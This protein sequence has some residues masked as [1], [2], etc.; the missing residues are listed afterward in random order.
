M[1]DICLPFSLTRYIYEWIFMN[2][3]MISNPQ[4]PSRFFPSFPSDFVSF[5]LDE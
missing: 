4:L 5:H 2:I 3:K 1:N